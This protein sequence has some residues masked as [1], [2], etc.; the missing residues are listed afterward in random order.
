M[1]AIEIDKTTICKAHC[2]Q[3]IE[4]TME[5]NS[6]FSHDSEKIAKSDKDKALK[7]IEM[8]KNSLSELQLRVTE[9]F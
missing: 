2:N 8:I 9:D 6:L 3:I 4:Q 1:H 7:N 5:L